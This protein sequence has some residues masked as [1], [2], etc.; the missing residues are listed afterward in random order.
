M[1]DTFH[2]LTRW[3]DSGSGSIVI[4]SS[5]AAVETFLV[6][7]AFNALKGALLSL[8]QRYPGEYGERL[9]GVLR[10]PDG[11]SDTD[12]CWAANSMMNTTTQLPD[13]FAEAL[14]RKSFGG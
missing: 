4:M 3:S 5:S 8:G 12:A 10:N 11:A 13:E 9:V 6:P 7:Q 2:W 14:L 1:A